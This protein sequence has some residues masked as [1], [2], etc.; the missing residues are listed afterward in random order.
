VLR[1]RPP[2]AEDISHI[3]VKRRAELDSAM[4]DMD[5]QSAQKDESQQ[6]NEILS[7]IKRFFSLNI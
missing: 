7:T 2:I 1:E 5:A 4:L 3:L 6:H